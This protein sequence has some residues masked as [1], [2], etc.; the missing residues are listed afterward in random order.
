[1]KQAKW[2]WLGL[3]ALAVWALFLDKKAGVTVVT[4]NAGG[5]V[6]QAPTSTQVPYYI[7]AP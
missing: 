5:N 3:G 7:A 6:P 2:I 4:P 1:M